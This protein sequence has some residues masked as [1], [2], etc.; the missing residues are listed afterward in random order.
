M[1]TLFKI[2]TLLQLYK[3]SKDDL[4]MLA[5]YQKDIDILLLIACLHALSKG[6]FNFIGL[7]LLP[8]YYLMNRFPVFGQGDLLIFMTLALPLKSIHW[9]TMMQCSFL[10]AALYV[11]YLWFV[12]KDKPDRLAFVPFIMWAYCYLEIISPICFN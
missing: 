2:L 1:D 3:M 5:I 7:I 9:F 12:K 10:F 8:F 11:F 6:N 4:K